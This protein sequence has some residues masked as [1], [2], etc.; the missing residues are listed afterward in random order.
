MSPCS[1]C[2]YRPRCIR[3]GWLSPSG[4][5]FESHVVIT[6]LPGCRG[7]EESGADI[8]TR[9]REVVRSPPQLGC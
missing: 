1:R 2:R 9:F 5:W 8:A 3:Y 4:F 7:F 6:P